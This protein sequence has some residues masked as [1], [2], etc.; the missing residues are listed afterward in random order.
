MRMT[1]AE[2]DKEARRDFHVKEMHYIKGQQ[3]CEI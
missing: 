1:Q 3:K 2:G